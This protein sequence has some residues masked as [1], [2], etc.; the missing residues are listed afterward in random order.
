MAMSTRPLRFVPVP[1]LLALLAS[2][3]FAQTPKPIASISRQVQPAFVLRQTGAKAAAASP[4]VLSDGAP[5]YAGDVLETGVGGRLR[6]ELNDG[7]TLNA[8]SRTRVRLPEGAPSRRFQLIQGIVRIQVPR[9]SQPDVVVEVL[10]V[11]ALCRS[12]GSVLVDARSAVATFIL[13]LGESPVEVEGERG[14]AT[15]RPGEGLWSDR[16]IASKPPADELLKMLAE[17]DI[18]TAPP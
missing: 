12:R 10:T 5:L 15:L 17:S 2:G 18:K 11:T 16:G 9:A 6:V 13:N 4:L 8:G 14:K 3:L 7:L 1:A